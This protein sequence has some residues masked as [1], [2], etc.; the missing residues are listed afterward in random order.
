MGVLSSLSKPM[1]AA[2]LVTALNVLVASG[3]ALAGLVSPKSILPPGAAPSEASLLFACYAAAR[4][5]PLALVALAAIAKRSSSALMV[6][7]LLS[8]IVQLADGGVGIYQGDP[9]KTF[10][11]L[12]IAGLEFWAIYRLWKSLPQPLAEAAAVSGNSRP[13]A[14]GAWRGSP[15]S[16]AGAPRVQPSEGEC[17]GPR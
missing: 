14:E 7:G 1:A 2:S 9:G 16:R 6:L 11:P 12:V 3:F 10:G 17:R 13:A 8:E 15:I 5:I 4:A